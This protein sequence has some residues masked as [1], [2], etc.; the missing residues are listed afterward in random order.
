MGMSQFFPS[1]YE[2]DFVCPRFPIG[3]VRSVFFFGFEPFFGL[4]QVLGQKSIIMPRWLDSFSLMIKCF[5]TRQPQN[6]SI[7]WSY[8]FCTYVYASFHLINFS[9][10]INFFVLDRWLGPWASTVT[11]EVV[12]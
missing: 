9:D 8:M 3:H 10:R 4:G 12:L 11:N 7:F 1:G 2:Y 5:L 6:S